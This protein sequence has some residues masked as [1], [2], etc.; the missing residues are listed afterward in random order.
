MPNLGA[1]LGAYPFLIYV[2]QEDAV[3][4]VHILLDGV[5]PVLC[6][7]QAEEEKER[8]CFSVSMLGACSS[9]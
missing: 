7:H 2:C 4:A 3:V 5:M 9:A 8:G 6:L 1:C